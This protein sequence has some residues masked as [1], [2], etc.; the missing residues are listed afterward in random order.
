MMTAGTIMTPIEVAEALQIDPEAV[1]GL[2][3]SSG[4]PAFHVVGQLRIRRV[5]LEAWIEA[6]VTRSVD[7]PQGGGREMPDIG[8]GGQVAMKEAPLPAVAS[9]P[10]VSA[11]TAVVGQEELHGRFAQ[12]LGRRVVGTGPMTAKPFEIDLGSPLP[13]R[14]RVYLFNATR[15]AGGR[16][17]GEHKIQLIMP[18]QKR[19]QRGTFDHG[20]ERVVV[21]AGYAV[22]DD[23]FILW[24]AG[25]YV[26]FAWS[27]NVQVKAET[28]IEASAGKIATQFRQLR[29]GDGETALETVIAAPAVKLGEAIERRIQLSRQRLMES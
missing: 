25:L 27:R 5:D 23:V 28:I 26:D 17:L 8:S 11:L 9:E 15:P 21:L 24:D 10:A 13:V 2:V 1:P 4:L 18:G 3:A 22:E 19:G 16:P 7:V 6:Q 12:A 14:L 29:R 20:D